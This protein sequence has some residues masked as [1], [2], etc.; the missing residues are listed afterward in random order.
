MPPAKQVPESLEREQQKPDIR[1]EAQ[2]T[3]RGALPAG[4][5]RR[6]HARF[7]VEMDVTLGSDHNF[8]GGLTENLSAGGVFVATHLLK[9]IG[10]VIELAIRVPE[11]DETIKGRGVVRWVREYHAESD[12]GPGMGILFQELEGDS[13]AIIERFVLRR[14]PLLYDDD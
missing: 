7:A 2:V 5:N 14:D 9:P 12:A 10:E 3:D 11:T 6:R 13:S 8:Y 4:D 1:T